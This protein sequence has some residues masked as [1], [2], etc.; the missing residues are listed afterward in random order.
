MTLP[1]GWRIVR[2]TAA[3][4][5]VGAPIEA[6]SWDAGDPRA[7]TALVRGELAAAVRSDNPAA[8]AARL[9][10]VD[11]LSF[12]GLSLYGVA[13]IRGGGNGARID[14]IFK[15]A[16]AHSALDRIAHVQLFFRAAT[17][18]NSNDAFRELDILARGSLD[19]MPSLARA[20]KVMIANDPN[21]EAALA[22]LLAS[23]PPWRQ[24]L[25]TYLCYVSGHSDVLARLYE[26]LRQSA[27]PPTDAEMSPYLAQLVHAGHIED[28]YLAW[29]G[30]LP[31]QR[32]SKVGAFYNG[33]FEH[34]MSDLPFDWRFIPVAGAS[35][36]I[37][38]RERERV[39]VVRFYGARVAFRHVVHLLALAPGTY[40]FSGS[41]KLLNLENERGLRWK[42]VCSDSSEPLAT[43]ELLTGTTPWLSLRA[44]FTIAAEGCAGQWLVLEIPARAAVEA[45]V[46]G[47]ARYKD[48]GIVRL[49][50]SAELR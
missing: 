22:R 24:A 49:D 23:R 10:S 42:I 25:L 27:A 41:V 37:A 14:E 3:D 21:V 29:L 1:L 43:T 48:L 32:L 30:H 46:S 9:L 7:L 39:L 16:A 34:P 31:E 5:L 11:P 33:G 38:S 50:T 13:L 28:A 8:A 45:E 18:G 15:A 12:E 36:E 2:H 20:V 26:Q 6:L 19:V 44:R 47:E 35:M 40:E 17:S 4:M